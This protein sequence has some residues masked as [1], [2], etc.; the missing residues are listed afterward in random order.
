[1]GC[2]EVEMRVAT[3]SDS[4]NLLNWRNHPSIR[5]VSRNNELISW[6]DHSQWFTALLNDSNRILLIGQ[7]QG[8]PVGV[9][10]FD[11]QNDQAEASIYLVP[12][13]DNK[14][15]GRDLLQSA[16]SWVAQHDP[17]IKGINAFVLGDNARS[18]RLFLS[19]GY[20][21]KS[22]SY[23]KRFQYE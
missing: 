21:I 6:E 3:L 7:H 15:R 23:F 17:E 1:M 19:A 9:V 13:S 16:E 8:S 18:H 11:I 20:E 14:G 4:E 12:E 2:H 10:R 5:A 22:T